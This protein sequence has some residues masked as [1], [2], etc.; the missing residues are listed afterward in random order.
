MK[1][2]AFPFAGGSSY[3]YVRLASEHQYEWITMDPPGHGTRMRFPL[4]QTIPEIVSNLLEPTLQAAAQ[5]PYVL[6]G[7]S[8]GAYV[9]L[10]MLDRL[11][12]MGA[13][14][15][16][17]LVLSGAVAPH[18][19]LP[20]RHSELP[21]K[22]FF[23]WIGSMGGMPKE[24]LSEP[25]LMELIEPILRTDVAAV[26]AYSDASERQ[27]QVLVRILLGKDDKVTKND[28]HAW[29]DCFS[30]K[31]EIHTLDGEHFFLFDDVEKVRAL[32]AE[33]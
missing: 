18:K 10:A 15:P 28:G 2:I 25:Q 16:Q 30:L 33:P 12:E 13:S 8:M 26:E 5:G 11:V 19:R 24:V 20:Q 29:V 22:E 4:L 7:H 1:I 6:F 21:G 17:R 14:L 27:H 23:D 9:A 3:S 31:P 32:I